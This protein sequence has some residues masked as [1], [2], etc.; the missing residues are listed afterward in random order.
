[1]YSF[2]SHIRVKEQ[3]SFMSPKERKKVTN[4]NNLFIHLFFGMQVDKHAFTEADHLMST[5]HDKKKLMLHFYTKEVS[6]EEFRALEK[7]HLS[8]EE[9]GIEVGAE[10]EP[11]LLLTCFLAHVF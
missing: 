10:T 5:L 9:Y 1:M 7:K 3:L 11:V 8:A 6:E 4:L 2:T